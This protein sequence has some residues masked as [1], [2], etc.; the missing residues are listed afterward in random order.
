MLLKYLREI[1]RILLFTSQFG[2]TAT[3]EYASYLHTSDKRFRPAN[4]DRVF[5]DPYLTW[6]LSIILYKPQ[7]VMLEVR[8]GALTLSLILSLKRLLI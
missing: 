3:M 2:S 8:Q 1:H 5:S 7:P 4:P 6:F